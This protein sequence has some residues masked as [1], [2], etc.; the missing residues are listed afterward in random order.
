MSDHLTGA[1][2]ERIVKDAVAKL[3]EHFETVQIFVTRHD[4]HVG[5]GACT[6]GDGNFYARMGQVRDWIDREHEASLDEVRSYG[7]S[8]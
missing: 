1:Q 5:T 3:M 6:R 7:G 8:E 2:R 4:S